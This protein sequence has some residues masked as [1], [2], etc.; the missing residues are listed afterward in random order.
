MQTYLIAG[1]SGLI[2]ARLTETLLERGV[3]VKVLSRGDKPVA[4]IDPHRWDI[5]AGTVDTAALD[6]VEVLV[7][8]AGAGLM[9]QRL[10]DE[11]K[12]ELLTSRVDGLKLL[13]EM[14]AAKEYP[15]KVL[16]SASAEGYYEPNADR[17]L[18]ESEPAAAGFLGQF[19]KI[20]EAEALQWEQIGVRVVI[21]RIGPVLGSRG[22]ALPMMLPPFSKGLAPHFGD[23]QN[24]LSWIHVDDMCATIIH[25]AENEGIRGAYNAAAPFPVTQKELN[26]AIAKALGRRVLAFGVP[27]LLPR[28]ALGERASVLVDSRRMS[29]EKIVATGFTFRFPSIEAAL[30]DLLAK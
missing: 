13:R 19:C 12:L 26:Q 14:V 8:L 11:R 16:I 25:Q 2:G 17:L 3:Q 24:A 6:D 10:T 7:H 5:A 18:V 4:G 15:I 21:N 29:V 1:A 9:D 27:K 22:G 20:W 23:G 30:E 28:L